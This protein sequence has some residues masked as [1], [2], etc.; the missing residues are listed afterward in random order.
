MGLL[1]AGAPRAFAF[2]TDGKPK[3]PRAGMRQRR[4][5]RRL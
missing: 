1:L 5:Y 3:R 2:Y 4:D